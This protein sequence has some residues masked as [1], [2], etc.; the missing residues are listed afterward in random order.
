MIYSRKDANKRIEELKIESA[1]IIK[2][3]KIYF[4]T[5]EPIG[6]RYEAILTPIGWA[7]DSYLLFG[8]NV[9]R[10]YNVPELANLELNELMLNRILKLRK[11]NSKL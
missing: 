10:K 11:E 2:E 8:D 7:I 3:F 4:H 5:I 6:I 9:V 1:K